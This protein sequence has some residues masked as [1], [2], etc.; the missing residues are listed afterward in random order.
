MPDYVER[1]VKSEDPDLSAEANRLLTE[2]LC[3]AVGAERVEV[4]ADATPGDGTPAP[5]FLAANRPLILVTFI[6][7]VVVGGIVSLVTGA[8]WALLIAVGL[9]A[10]GTVIVGAGAIRLTTQVE[11]V[12]P[13]RATRLEAEGV[14]DPDEKLTELVEEYAGAKPRGDREVLGAGFNERAADTQG[15]PA[16]ATAE[17]AS[18]V[19]PSGGEGSRP[20]GG[21]SAVELLPWWFVL[22]TVVASVVVAIVVGGRMWV[23][24]A[25]IGGLGGGWLLLQDSMARGR[26][27]QEHGFSK[28]VAA[29]A[30]A[31]ALMAA[32]G[33]GLLVIIASAV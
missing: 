22:G 7:A 24:P 21:R 12:S 3:E 25:I 10:L 32:A 6:A 29:T 20:G 5:G 26:R 17:Q 11:H 1:E 16:E 15:Q 27:P 33:I 19:T 8:W 18:A 4:P 28:K 9:H 2:E 31:V 23:L 30:V 14:V 13:A